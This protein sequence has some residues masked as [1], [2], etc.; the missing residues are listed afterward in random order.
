[1]FDPS[2]LSVRQ[3]LA[4][5]VSMHDELLRRRLVRTRNSPLGDLA[6]LVALRAYGGVLA[7]NS[8]RSYD[9]RADDGRRIQVKA[10]LVDPADRRSQ[11]FL[12]FRWWD[13]DAALFM[14]FD[15]RTYDIVWGRELSSIEAQSLGRRVEH[16]DSSAVLVPQ[17]SISG[18]DMTKALIAAFD[19]LDQPA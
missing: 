17:V 9:L 7:P 16:T 2:E 8:D 1:M 3:L 4:T 18:Q 10:R 6:E 15:S 11:P 19:R 12:A 5:C 13:F 14:L